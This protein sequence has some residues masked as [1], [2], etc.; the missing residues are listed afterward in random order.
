[1]K[2]HD[3]LFWKKRIAEQQERGQSVAD[4]CERHGLSRF[5]FLRWR[6]RLARD[7]VPGFVELQ[8]I[9]AEGKAGGCDAALELRI[10]ADIVFIFRAMP[11]PQV[12]TEF[13]VALRRAE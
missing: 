8:K 9:A 12:I 6:R 4:Y 10:G 2:R 7:V 1:M 5:T 13:A 3:A 11:D